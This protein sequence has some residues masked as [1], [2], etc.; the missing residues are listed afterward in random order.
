MSAQGD[1]ALLLSFHAYLTE[2]LSSTQLDKQASPLRMA[3]CILS[4]TKF[5]LLERSV[6]QAPATEHSLQISLA[7]AVWHQR[8]PCWG[9]CP[10]LMAAVGMCHSCRPFEKGLAL[11]LNST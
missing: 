8:R 7:K 9:G 5:N 10:C 6:G 4:S 3:C 2:A 11:T 1:A